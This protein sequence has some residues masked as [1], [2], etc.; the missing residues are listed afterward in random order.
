MGNCDNG[1]KGGWG[2]DWEHSHSSYWPTS[3][4]RSLLFEISRDLTL[5]DQLLIKYNN[6]LIISNHIGGVT[7]I[8]LEN[9][10]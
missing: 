4:I 6:P 8:I 9:S 7:Q 3:L 10:D 5:R 2:V 1:L